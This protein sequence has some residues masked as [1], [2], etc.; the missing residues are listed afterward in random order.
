MNA[1][2]GF[3]ERNH[4]IAEKTLPVTAS[5]VAVAMFFNEALQG[6]WIH[7]NGPDGSSSIAIK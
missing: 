7:A 1:S 4:L 5:P 3:V 6:G 2:Y